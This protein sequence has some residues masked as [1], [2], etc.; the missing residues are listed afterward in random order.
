MKYK[1]KIM[2]VDGAKTLKDEEGND[3]VFDTKKKAKEEQ[4]RW[5]NSVIVNYDG[6]S[7]D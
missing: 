4:K 5:A 3:I 2:L 6:N 1:L 7:E